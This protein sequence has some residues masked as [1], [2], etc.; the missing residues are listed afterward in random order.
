MLTD[1]RSRKIRLIA[2]LLAMCIMLAVL[3][4][5]AYTVVNAHHACTGD[6][7]PI[8][9]HIQLL[10]ALLNSFTLVSVG[11]LL[12]MLFCKTKF[13]AVFHLLGTV[14]FRTPVTLFDRM[15]N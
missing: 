3:S 6:S 5:S 13:N 2:L 9:N 12:G 7:C 14:L 10:L 4:T 11:L 1:S 8:C 15:N